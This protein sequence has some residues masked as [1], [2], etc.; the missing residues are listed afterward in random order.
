MEGRRR[1]QTLLPTVLIIAVLVPAWRAAARTPPPSCQR[2]CGDV[3][4]PYPFGI[5]GTGAWGVNC[6]LPGFEIRCVVRSGAGSLAVV[7][8]VLADTNI[9]VLSLSVMPRPEARLLLPVAWQCFNSSGGITN[10]S[11]ATVRFNPAGVYR[12]SDDRNRFVVLGCNTDAFTANSPTRRGLYDHS[13]YAGCFTYCRD[14]GSAQDGRCASVG[15]CQ[16]DIPPGLTDNA[17]TFKNWGRQE[18]SPCD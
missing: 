14:K 6:S 8:P 9:T 11:D 15:C 17:V 18:W 16:V 13:Y 10:Y 2:R 12:I 3:D 1:S 4:I 7:E 5:A